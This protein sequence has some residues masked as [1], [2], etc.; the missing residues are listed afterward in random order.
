M[1]RRKSLLKEIRRYA[2]RHGTGVDV[3][4]RA[5]H[6]KISF[7]DRRTVLP[8]HTEINELTARSIRHQL[9]MGQ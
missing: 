1:V 8:R 5:N 4:E 2:R 7:G 6:T 3:A 9:G